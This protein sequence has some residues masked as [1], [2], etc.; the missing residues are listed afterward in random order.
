MKMK[1][2]LTPATNP[3]IVTVDIPNLDKAAFIYDTNYAETMS[4]DFLRELYCTC[5]LDHLSYSCNYSV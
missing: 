2:I 3:T 5:Q 1:E 4:L